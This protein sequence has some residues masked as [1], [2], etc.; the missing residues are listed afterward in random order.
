[1]NINTRNMPFVEF[2][3]QEMPFVKFNG[4]TVYEAWKNLIASGVPPLTLTK[5][6]GKSKLPSEYQEVEY[7][8]S[9]GTQYIDTGH[10]V[11][12]YDELELA[13]Q[14][15]SLE[16]LL[17][18]VIVGCNRD[19]SS[20]GQLWVETYNQINR[21]YARFGSSN[22]V[23][24]ESTTDQYEGI[25]KLKK[26]SLEINGK[27]IL[28]PLFE[29]LP[30]TPLNIFGAKVLADN[31]ELMGAYVR[32]SY[33]KI[34]RNSEIIR[35]F[36]PCYR[37]SDNVI[38]MYDTVTDTFYTNQGTGTLLKGKNLP[39]GVDLV[40]YKIFGN[41]IQGE[42]MV[43]YPY[44]S[45]NGFSSNGIT[46]TINSDKSITANGTA[47]ADAYFQIGSIT[48]E[49]NKTYIIHKAPK[50]ASSTTYSLLLNG[51]KRVVENDEYVTLTEEKTGVFYVLIHKGNTLD[52]I[53]FYPRIVEGPTP[54]APLEVESVGE[55]TKNLFQGISIVGGSNTTYTNGTIT[56][57]IADTS[58]GVQ[59][60]LQAYK[61]LSFLYHIVSKT[62]TNLG[63]FYLNFTKEDTFNQICFGLNGTARDTTIIIDV[64]TLENG[65]TYTISA[66]MLNI[67]QG[68]VSWNNTQIEEGNTLTEY[69]P[70]GYRIPVKVRGKNLLDLS[71]IHGK[72]YTSNGATMS[73]GEDGGISVSGTPTGYIGTNI[74]NKPNLKGITTFS[75]LGDFTNIA[76]QVVLRDKSNNIL[77][78]FTL[79]GAY[80]TE[81]INM[82]NYQT[83]DNIMHYIKR[84]ANN[85]QMRG[86]AYLQIE[87]GSG[88]K[89]YE[90]YKGEKTTNIYLSEPLRK[91]DDYADYI[92]FDNKKVI[93]NVEKLVL[94][95]SEYWYSSVENGKRRAFL[96]GRSSVG[97]NIVLSDKYVKDTVNYAYPDI[98]K[99]MVNGAGSVIMGL[100]NN[101]F[102]D[103]ETYKTWLKTNNVDVY[104]PLATPTEEPIELPNIPTFKG[105]TIL[106][107][108]ANIQPSNME[109][110]Y[111]GKR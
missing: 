6:K 41:S 82:D 51:V 25:L 49:A 78:D 30:T 58:T 54:E 26:E 104:L 39:D 5:C 107:A 14:L 56:Q 77:L 61:N 72:S 57:K 50:G 91:I 29:G 97:K 32:I 70:Y 38:G 100:D 36:I 67:T 98:N 28:T 60:K 17:D 24:A 4:V 35:H 37:K 62:I 55:K 92:D 111:K 69:E 45:Q 34:T 64:S 87:E 52:N 19:N 59:F 74:S 108:G 16:K 79:G 73:V 75:I 10:V 71:E 13:Y 42:N 18:K 102:P 63:V 94:N 86:T 44:F 95:G 93:R 83:Y 27:T 2:N 90:P 47:T 1:M 43:T 88:T 101:V 3:G 21:W 84:N 65:K 110:V 109:V 9:T 48:F 85:V 66:N 8:E 12:E 99:I 76:W 53:T 11:Q 89:D 23:N 20:K 33:L 80:R 105:T 7:I 46:F 40:D 96:N 31:N 22:S 68:T 106:E 81:T 103:V 15:T